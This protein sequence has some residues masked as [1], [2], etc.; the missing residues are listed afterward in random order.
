MENRGLTGAGG[1]N[2]G[3]YMGEFDPPDADV[4]SLDIVLTLKWGEP[5]YSRTT[6]TRGFT[7]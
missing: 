5:W 4:Y 6:V 2:D 3:L 1:R 7:I